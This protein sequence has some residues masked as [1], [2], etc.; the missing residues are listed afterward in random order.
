MLMIILNILIYST[1]SWNMVYFYHYIIFGYIQLSV[2]LTNC[3]MVYLLW[4]WYIYIGK[5]M[6]EGCYYF[7]VC[8]GNTL[9]LFSSWVYVKFMDLYW[10][11]QPL[12]L[13]KSSIYFFTA[14][15]INIAY[16]SINIIYHIYWYGN[17]HLG[18]TFSVCRF[19][20]ILRL[21]DIFKNV[22]NINIL[23]CICFERF[24]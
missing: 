17:Y 16:L 15:D 2:I 7:K 22:A 5:K 4:K 21:A 19:I 9:A 24:N 13:D 10:S 11:P 23:L 20:V 12:P 3:K 8:L 18:C 6:L 14:W 1:A